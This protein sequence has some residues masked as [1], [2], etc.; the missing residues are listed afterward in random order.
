[1]NTIISRKKIGRAT[2][3]TI[4]EDNS[5]SYVTK[6]APPAKNSLHK[7]FRF[8]FGGS[9]P[10]QNE[11]RVLKRIKSL[12][13][14]RIKIPDIYNFV[15]NKFY[16]CAY[17]EYQKIDNTNNMDHVVVKELIN[18]LNSINRIKRPPIWFCVKEYAFRLLESPM[19]TTLFLSFYTR[20]IP[21]I[22][23]LNT[24]RAILR[25][26]R[27]RIFNREKLSP[28]MVHND[29][30]YN[31]IIIDANCN[32]YIIDWEDAIWEKQ[33]PLVDLTDIALNVS[34]GELDSYLLTEYFASNNIKI[35]NT[36]KLLHCHIMFGYI[37]SLLNAINAKSL[38][39]QNIKILVNHLNIL[40]KNVLSDHQSWDKI[41]NNL[42]NNN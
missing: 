36:N 26:N 27:Y 9:L 40:V 24:I 32:L 4:K 30:G 14:K 12:D 23:V 15:E 42:N 8:C 35:N 7:L 28:R 29:M 20:N 17:I 6:Y 22:N 5:N 41:I 31:N 18:T 19:R 38:P 2:Y 33:W 21:N 16:E 39:S 1:M 13:E 25:L 10:F 3:L 11:F 37:R 34:T